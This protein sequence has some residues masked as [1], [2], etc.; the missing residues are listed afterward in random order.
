MSITHATNEE[1]RQRAEACGG[2][3]YTANYDTVENPLDINE[4]EELIHEVCKEFAALAAVHK[5]KPDEE[6]RALY[7]KQCA[8]NDR[9]SRFLNQ[10]H[11][12]IANALMQRSVPSEIRDA[13]FYMLRTKKSSSCPQ[14]SPRKKKIRRWKPCKISSSTLACATNNFFFFFFLWWWWG[15]PGG[16]G[17][18]E[19][20][21]NKILLLLPTHPAF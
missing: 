8:N 9:K 2:E 3:Y 17:G 11:K 14:T 5:D 1:I 18:E 15:G 21:I 20:C 19:D 7:R 4:V 12:T 13:I 10:T 16:P 6:L